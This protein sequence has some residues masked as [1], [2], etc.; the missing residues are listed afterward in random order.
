VIVPV[1]YLTLWFLV[2]CAY[3]AVSC[4]SAYLT[5][6]SSIGQRR[7]ILA[8]PSLFV[9]GLDRVV[10][11]VVGQYTRYNYPLYL[12]YYTAD[13]I[14]VDGLYLWLAWD[15]ARAI[16]SRRFFPKSIK[17]TTVALTALI[18]AF[19]GM[20]TTPTTRPDTLAAYRAL[21]GASI[22]TFW[23][24]AVTLLI[25]VM[26]NGIGFSRTGFWITSAALVR[27]LSSLIVSSVLSRRV[28]RTVYRAANTTDT[29]IS[30]IVA[31]SWAWTLA[32][33]LRHD[34]T[35]RHEWLAAASFGDV[36]H[37]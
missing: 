10:F 21:Y 4:T 29:I 3:F 18:G 23:A 14:I 24:I 35:Q 37:D 33:A 7:I 5:V 15:I 26:I 34:R 2:T 30:L 13:S 32:S 9:I 11:F 19:V 22:S 17:H 1:W 31:I 6:R 28:T 12:R 20:I 36:V 27:Q 8:W 16:P 25:L